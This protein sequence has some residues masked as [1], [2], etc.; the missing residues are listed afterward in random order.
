MDLE[1]LISNIAAKKLNLPLLIRLRGGNP[2]ITYE[3]KEIIDLKK[4]SAVYAKNISDSKQQELS[5]L[6][7]FACDFASNH[8]MNLYFFVT[9][10]DEQ[11]YFGVEKNYEKFS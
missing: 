6:L 8:K 2:V 5:S 9:E 7:E 4:E 3:I 10:M 1:I 11:E